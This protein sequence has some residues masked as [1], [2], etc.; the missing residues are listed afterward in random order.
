MDFTATEL[1]SALEGVLSSGWLR[2][3]AGGRGTL[4]CAARQHV[5]EAGD[6]AAGHS[7]AALPWSEQ[8]CLE[9]RVLLRILD[10]SGTLES[11]NGWDALRRAN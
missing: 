11:V 7:V 8:E 10:P 1:P 6:A 2:S 3:A 4:A 5:L 9:Q